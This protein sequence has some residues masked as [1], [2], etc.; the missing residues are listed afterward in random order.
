MRF[1]ADLMSRHVRRVGRRAVGGR[2]HGT[3]ARARPAGDAH[4]QRR[5]GEGG[6]VFSDDGEEGDSRAEH[7]HREPHPDDLPG[8]FRRRISAAAGRCLSRHRR[9]RPRLPQQR[10]DVG[11]GHSADRGHH[12]H[13]RGRRRVS[14]ADVRSHPDDRRQR[15]VSRRAG[16][17]AGGDRCESIPPKIWAARRCT[18]RSAA[19]STSANPTTSRAW[20]AFGKLVDKMGNT[21]GVFDRKKPVEPRCGGRDLRHLRFLD[22]RASTT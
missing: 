4:R 8:R 13:V 3:G 16:A 19:R 1:L 11:D 2:G 9:F 5:H 17:G 7:C 10:R 21:G 15:T 6:R 12:G 18:R 14:A 22:P 20:R